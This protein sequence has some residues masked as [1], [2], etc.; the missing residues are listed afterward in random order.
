MASTGSQV[1]SQAGLQPVYGAAYIPINQGAAQ[2]GPVPSIALQQRFLE[3]QERSLKDLGGSRGGAVTTLGMAGLGQSGMTQSS[4][5]GT[6]TPPHVWTAAHQAIPGVGPSLRTGGV[7]AFVGGPAGVPMPPSRPFMMPGP[8][9][10]GPLSGGPL[11][12]GLPTALPLAATVPSSGV[13]RPA[14]RTPSP[15]S[16]S[17]GGLPQT[18]IPNTPPSSS[19]R[20]APGGAAGQFDR[21]GGPAAQQP[22]GQPFT[23][24]PRPPP[25]A[26]SGYQANATQSQGG[27]VHELAG[28]LTS[29]SSSRGDVDDLLG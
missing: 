18:P 12:G 19:A 6:A 26:L 23:P 8:P 25:P 13:S 24:F 29:G 28:R 2:Q 9:S 7:G 1:S 20:T 22:A 27:A 21:G 5:S 14:R 4:R 17:Q 3:L 11:S 16:G 15:P 10:G